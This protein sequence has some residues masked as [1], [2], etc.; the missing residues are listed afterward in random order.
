MGVPKASAGRSA[1]PHDS[2]STAKA[3]LNRASQAGQRDRISP[4]H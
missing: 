2:H 3:E 1:S 4:P